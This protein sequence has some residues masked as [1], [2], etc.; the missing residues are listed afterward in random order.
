MVEISLSG[1]GEGPGEAT[2]RGYSTTVA[3]S[4]IRARPGSIRSI[5]AAMTLRIHV[6]HAR[7]GSNALRARWR[8]V[9]DLRDSLK[10]RNPHQPTS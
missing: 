10:Q 6:E 8:W 9:S 4:I 1:S 5:T 7:E 3:K 2:T